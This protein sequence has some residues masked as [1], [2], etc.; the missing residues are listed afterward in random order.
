[1]ELAPVQLH[2]LAALLLVLLPA[3]LP[4]LVLH[5]LVVDVRLDSGSL[6]VHADEWRVVERVDDWR[7]RDV[8][9]LVRVRRLSLTVPLPLPHHDRG[10][11]GPVPAGL[12]QV[13][14]DPGTDVAGPPGG[15]EAQRDGRGGQDRVLHT[16]R[17]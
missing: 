6:P 17:T 15:G 1:M 9:Q 11:T 8:L 2:P 10:L 13:G 14:L 5:E 4:V 12:E 7:L 3:A 16:S